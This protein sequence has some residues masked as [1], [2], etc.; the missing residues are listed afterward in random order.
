MATTIIQYTDNVPVFEFQ[1]AY[2]HDVAIQNL[3][4]TYNNPQ[5]YTSTGAVAVHFTGNN[6]SFFGDDFCR[7]KILNANT[8]FGIGGV[9]GVTVWGYLFDDIS[10]SDRNAS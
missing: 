6:S 7:L 1:S 9:G 5:P 3:C 4:L 2:I 10:C 8:A